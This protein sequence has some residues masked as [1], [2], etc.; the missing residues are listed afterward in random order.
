MYNQYVAANADKAILE[1]VDGEESWLLV[2]YKTKPCNQSWVQSR[3][4]K[5]SKT[6]ANDINDTF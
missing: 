6:A 1:N 2:S 3:L 5:Q 4:G